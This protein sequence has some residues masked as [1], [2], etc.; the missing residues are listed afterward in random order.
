MKLITAIKSK[1]T[2]ASFAIFFSASSFAADSST[3]YAGQAM[4]SLLTQANDLIAKVWPVVVAV[5]GAGLAIRLFK[6][7]SSKAV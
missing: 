4:D 1:I 6:K 5:V 2:T 3:D 7:F